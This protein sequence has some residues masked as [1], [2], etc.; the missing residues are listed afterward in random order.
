MIDYE[1][2][3]TSISPASIMLQIQCP[4]AIAATLEA[5][6]MRAAL[7]ALKSSPGCFH[8]WRLHHAC[9]RPG[10]EEGGAFAEA[11]PGGVLLVKAT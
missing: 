3:V 9:S 11:A 5:D 7:A 1:D 4:H 10:Q 2:V 8:A 6:G